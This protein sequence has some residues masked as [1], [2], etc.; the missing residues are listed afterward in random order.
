MEKL[1]IG[2]ALAAVTGVSFIAYKHPR[3]FRKS[4]GLYLVYGTWAV[5]ICMFAYNLAII[6]F[7]SDLYDYCEGQCSFIR[8]AKANAI[9]GSTYFFLAVGWVVY[10]AILYALPQMLN[11]HNRRKDDPP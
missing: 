3:A 11:V 2:L 7:T 9:V 8:E 4:I 10:L 6:Q 1:F 5:M